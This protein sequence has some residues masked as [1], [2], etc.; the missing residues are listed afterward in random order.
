MVL[1]VK[2]SN[3]AVMRR[4]DARSAVGEE[5]R[6]TVQTASWPDGTLV[7]DAGAARDRVLQGRQRLT[8]SVEAMT[9]R[10]RGSPCGGVTAELVGLPGSGK[11]TL[12]RAMA[13]TDERVADGIHHR[14]WQ[15]DGRVLAERHLA[16]ADHPEGLAATTGLEA[17]PRADDPLGTPCRPTVEVSLER[18]PHSRS[19]SQGPVFLLYRL[20]PLLRGT[21]RSDAYSA[22]GQT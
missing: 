3:I 18:P 4:S 1:R 2:V 21:P 9:M 8:L 15:E 10:P 20:A 22:P 11:S 17:G 16:L 5:P 13:E 7:V 19:S 6:R 12:V 14:S